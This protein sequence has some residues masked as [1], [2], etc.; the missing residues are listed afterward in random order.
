MV[1]EIESFE[2]EKLTVLPNFLETMGRNVAMEGDI[3]KTALKSPFAQYFCVISLS[4]LL[5]NQ[6]PRLYFWLQKCSITSTIT[7]EFKVQRE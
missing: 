7:T 5:V 4:S 1:L 3:A 6:S 2:L